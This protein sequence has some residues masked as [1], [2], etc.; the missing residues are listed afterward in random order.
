MQQ[1]YLVDAFTLYAASAVAANTVL[2]SIVGGVLPLAGLNM[3]EA[4]GFGWGN[5][6]IA[7]ISLAMVPIPFAFYIF[8]E[9]VRKS[10]KV[11]L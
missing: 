4:L 9:R 8:G 5:S 2:R 1:Q 10:T 6:L 11:T 3:Y 7:F